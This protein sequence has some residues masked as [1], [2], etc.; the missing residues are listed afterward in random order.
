MVNKWTS[1]TYCGDSLRKIRQL[2]DESIDLIFADP[3]YFLSSQ[4]GTTVSG[5]KRVSVSKGEWDAPV[6]FRENVKFTRRWLRECL[7]VLKPT[8]TLWVSGTRHSIHIVG[9][10]LQ[11]LGADLFNEVAWGKMNAA[12]NISCTR[13]AD[14]HETLI[15]ARKTTDCRPTFNYRALKDM[16]CPGD[17]IKRHGSQ[18]RSIWIVNTPRKVEKQFGKHPTQKPEALLERIILG[19]SN[20]GDVVLDPFAGSGTTGVIAKR[21]RRRAILIEQNPE[22]YQTLRKRLRNQRGT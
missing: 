10:V 6:T 4:R 2:G 5:G 11:S 17:V 22:F 19:F 8:G 3:P 12:P 14:M 18:M 16:E 7:R 20:R 1:R 9:A 21:L 13:L 15:C